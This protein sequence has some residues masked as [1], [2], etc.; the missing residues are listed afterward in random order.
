ME[1]RIRAEIVLPTYLE[2]QW[3]LVRGTQSGSNS[4]LVA[5]GLAF[6]AAT[7]DAFGNWYS[8]QATV[9][10]LRALLTAAIRATRRIDAEVVVQ[11]NGR[12]VQR[13]DFRNEDFGDVHL[14]TDLSEHVVTGE[15]LI[16]VAIRG[17]GSLMYQVVGTHYRPWQDRPVARPDRSLSLDVRYER[18]Q[19]APGET[20]RVQAT[21]TNHAAGPM[22]Q[23][24]VSIGR[25]PGFDLMPEDLDNLV[26]QQRAARWEADAR[27]IV[28]YLMGL[29]PE[30]PHPLSFRLRARYPMQGNAPSSSIDSYYE[31]GSGEVTGPVALGVS[32]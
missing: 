9:N 17:E 13:Y 10:S 16:N 22:D 8:T 1:T 32:D 28:F 25:P 6:L 2:V 4:T 11:H 19:L 26:A 7:K 15:N 30:T 5:E 24:I 23:V 14:T 27:K 29:P 31:P 3:V 20:T 21:A 12:T 18:T